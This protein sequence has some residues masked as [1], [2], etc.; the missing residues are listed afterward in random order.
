MS[1]PGIGN[2]LHNIYLVGGILSNLEMDFRYT[3]EYV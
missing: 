1:L 2:Y 3:G